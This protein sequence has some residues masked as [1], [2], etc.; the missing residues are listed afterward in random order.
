MPLARERS[1]YVLVLSRG[2]DI[3]GRCKIAEE[4]AHGI[5]PEHFRVLFAVKNNK[6]FNPIDIRVF[7]AQRIMLQ[8]DNLSNAFEKFG[9]AGVWGGG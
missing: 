4:L 8:A 1:F 6:P 7:G 3:L 2:G 9:L 5:G